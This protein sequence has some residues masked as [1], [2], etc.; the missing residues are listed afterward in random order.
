MLS[1]V[2]KNTNEL[3][4]DDLEGFDSTQRLSQGWRHFGPIRK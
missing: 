1:L 2:T 3:F 4:T